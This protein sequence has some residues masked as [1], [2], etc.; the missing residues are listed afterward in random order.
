MKTKKN[1]KKSLQLDNEMSVIR[2]THEGVEEENGLTKKE[3][4]KNFLLKSTMDSK[5]KLEIAKKTKENFEK[6]LVEIIDCPNENR[7]YRLAKLHR[8]SK[9][10]LMNAILVKQKNNN[11]II[12]E[13]MINV[14]LEKNKEELIQEIIKE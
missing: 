2:H 6:T 8:L 10:V 12:T 9:V 13:E 14:L 7:I 5:S 3:K 4:V 1:T 11:I